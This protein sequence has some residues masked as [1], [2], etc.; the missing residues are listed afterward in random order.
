MITEMTSELPTRPATKAAGGS[1]VP[2]HPL[3]LA[4]LALGG[5]V[6]RELDRGRRDHREREDRRHVVG[7]ALDVDARDVGVL[8]DV[9]SRKRKI[10]GSSAVKKTAAGLRQKTFWS[11]RNWCRTSGDAAH[12]VASRVVRVLGE[13]QVDVLEARAAA[14]SA[15]AARRRARP[16]S[17]SARAGPGPGPRAL[18]ETALGVDPRA[19][20]ARESGRSRRAD[21]CRQPEADLGARLAVAAEIL[22]RARWRRSGPPR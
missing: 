17:W 14:P 16:P 5:Q 19:R 20:R 13:L 8:E 18:S 21:P 4:G 12:C 6:G 7:R 1:G 15:R 11:K 2:A 22:R 10:S 9:A 3:E